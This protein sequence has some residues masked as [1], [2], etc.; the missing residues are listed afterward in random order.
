MLINLKRY[1][2]IKIVKAIV[3][4]ICSL[5]G[6][7]KE[8]H[9]NHS[10][11]NTL[12]FK[13]LR[14]EYFK[15]KILGYYYFQENLGMSLPKDEIDFILN[16]PAAYSIMKI[17]KNA[18]GK[19][20]FDGKEF[21]SKFTIKNYIFPVFGYFISAFI[22]MAYIVFYKELL[23]YVFDKISYIFFC[24]I[25]MSIFVP[26]LITCKIKISEINDVLYLEKITS[27]RKKT[28]QD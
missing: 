3:L 19:Y 28:K 25:I 1:I 10:Y 22:V 12:K 18:Y 27:T 7:F 17:I 23:K 5:I 21:K 14:E 4:G 11:K 26:L 13:S 24:I 15:D 20:E 9:F 6:C 16:S 2:L 8:F